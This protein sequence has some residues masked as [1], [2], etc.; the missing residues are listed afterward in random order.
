MRS[1]P[2]P[3]PEALVRFHH[4]L[5]TQTRIAVLANDPARQA[6]DRAITLLA[7][8][9]FSQEGLKQRQQGVF[10]KEAMQ[11]DAWLAGQARSES[12]EMGRDDLLKREVGLAEQF[13]ERRR[14]ARVA[15]HE[16]V[17]GYSRTERLVWQ[18]LGEKMDGGHVEDMQKCPHVE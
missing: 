9:A 4:A 18:T 11:R 2:I 3:K 5:N 10:S 15:R 17:P 14:R 7:L 16:L 13:L 6:I 12:F 1:V 8:L